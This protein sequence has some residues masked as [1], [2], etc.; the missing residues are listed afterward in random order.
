[1]PDVYATIASADVEVQER[2]ADVLD[3]RAN[4]PQQRAMLDAYLDDVRFS[5][6]T[7]VLELGSGTGAVTRRLV[8]LP[9][10]SEVVGVDLSPVFLARARMRCGDEPR[11]SYVLGDARE[12]PFDSGCFDAVV[13]H[14]TLC[15]VPGCERVLAEARRVSAPGG[16]LVVFDGDYATTTVAVGE[17]DPLQACVDAAI[18]ALVHDQYLIRRLPALVRRAG[19][20]LVRV[21]SHG[22]VETESPAYMLTLIDRGAD[23]LLAAGVVGAGAAAALRA[24][25]HRRARAGEFFGHIAYT[26][27]I[28][29]R[30]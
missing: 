13:A 4:D 29:R 28:A 17:S 19:W 2:L 20:N 25:A 9:G 30:A 5:P 12:L 23:A 6:E 21:R 3:L 27:L 14:T 10:V 18:R 24:E 1:M 26:S 8:D 7:R 11:I 22:Y 16:A 15:H